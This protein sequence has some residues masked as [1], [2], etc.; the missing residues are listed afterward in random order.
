MPPVGPTRPP[1]GGPLSGRLEKAG[2]KDSWYIVESTMTRRDGSTFESI[3]V[4]TIRPN[5]FE[6]DIAVLRSM[7]YNRAFIPSVDY[8][9]AAK[10]PL[11]AKTALEG[12]E[13]IG[14]RKRSG[15]DPFVGW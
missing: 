9:E 11:E 14:D 3:D 2:I 6:R 5:R 4:H 8:S 15:K 13:E 1:R 10:E 7:G 12:L